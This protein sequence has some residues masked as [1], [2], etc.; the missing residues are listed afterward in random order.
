MYFALRNTKLHFMRFKI[1]IAAALAYSVSF[2]VYGQNNI[3]AIFR[4]SKPGFYQTSI[5]K[6]DR[7]V[8]ERTEPAR[9]RRSF[10]ADL[11]GL[12]VPNKLDL[13]KNRQWHNTPISQG[14]TGT[15][16]C[17]SSTSFLESEAYRIS[18][19]KV[20]LSEIYTV[21]WE[22]VEKARRYIQERG[23]SEFG[24]GSEANATTRIWK[25]YGVVP[26]ETY[27]GLLNGR[28]YHN[29]ENMFNEMESYLKGM[30]AN[31]S[32]NE[33][34]AIATIKAIMNHYIGEPPSKITVNNR[35]VTP[36]QYLTE[37]LKLNPDDYVDILSYTQEPFWQ[38]VEY[39]V[40]DNWWHSAD[41]YNVPLDVYIT[42]LK[43]AIRNGYT[44]SIGGDVS[45]PGF[46]RYT[47]CA[48]IPEF[49]IPS[50]YINDDARQFRFSNR[51]TTDDHGMHLV[52]FLEKDGKDWYLIK[53]S[54]AGS[55]NNDVNA[56]EFGYYFFSEDYVKLKMMD[57][58]VHKDAVKDL[59][60]KFID[61]K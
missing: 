7:E 10:S 21:Y 47:Q 48:V 6:D 31:S 24:E 51:T 13:Y 15:C 14:N 11:S 12:E 30:K 42:T 60:V 43:N 39:K 41:Y 61:I 35:E 25:K 44:V 38:Q 16:W 26:A 18:K 19:A 34:T 33:E 1:I 56:K 36:N 50:A 8:A 27:T 3:K 57:F 37:I 54:S 46:D 58:M 49:D 17:F 52:G 23:D 28:K 53:D 29:H 32:W 45:E 20:R 4:E 9:I 22:Y 55:R 2:S 59:L 5:L 40:P